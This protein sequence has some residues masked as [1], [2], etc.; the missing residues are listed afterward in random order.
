MYD[1]LT[2]RIECLAEEERRNYYNHK[3]IP[4]RSIVDRQLWLFK[5]TRWVTY[6][7]DPFDVAKDWVV[8]QW[9]SSRWFGDAPIHNWVLEKLQ[10]LARM[11]ADEHLRRMDLY[12][13]NL[14][15]KINVFVPIEQLQLRDLRCKI[16]FL[17]SAN[18][19]S[20]KIGTSKNVHLRIRSIS[21]AIKR[22]LT[23]LA[24]MSGDC[25]I[26]QWLHQRFAKARIRGEWFR[27]VPEL[28]EY[29]DGI[30]ASV[31]AS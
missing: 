13:R 18:D 6:W 21:Q 9:T 12:R 2:Y 26:E 30:K 17:Q 23:L 31:E 22:Q 16:Y 8:R 5:P 14:P 28:L 11:E 25:G 20:I 1:R 7:R 10:L 29:I 15:E 24:T 19:G 27:Q 3:P 4:P